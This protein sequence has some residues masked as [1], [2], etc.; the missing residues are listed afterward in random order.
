M[1]KASSWAKRERI[2]MKLIPSVI[3]GALALGT[4]SPR[5]LGQS[6]EERFR[7][8]FT[9]AGYATAFGAALGAA[10]LSFKEN[11]ENHLRY[12]AIGASMGFIGG[13]VL[14]TYVIFTPGFADQKAGLDY[15]Y[16][17][18]KPG[19]TVSPLIDTQTHNIQ[20][21]RGSWTVAQF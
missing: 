8:L 17:S 10:A 1:H 19:V 20:G 9:T 14:G 13:S 2:A 4:L 5:A 21:L 15:T 6:T 18:N 7:D 3:I 16:A 11:P 12:V